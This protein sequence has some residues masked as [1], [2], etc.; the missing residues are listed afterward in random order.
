MNTITESKP[1]AV[2]AERQR[3]I[4]LIKSVDNNRRLPFRFTVIGASAKALEIQA[5]DREVEKLARR[6]EEAGFALN[7]TQTGF[8]GVSRGLTVH[9]SRTTAK[10]QP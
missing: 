1:G 2:E 5:P 8:V 6:L 10:G 3:R 9:A 4:R 7:Y